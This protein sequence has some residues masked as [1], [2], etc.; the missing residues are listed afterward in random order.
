ME[1]I[2]KS[3][4][5]RKENFEQVCVWRGAPLGDHTG[6]DVER[7]F[8]EAGFR[9]QYLENVLT[10]PD[11]DELGRPIPETGGRDDMLI[12]IHKDDLAKFTVARFQFHISWIED[13]TSR[14]NRGDRLY[15][16]YVKA[17]NSWDADSSFTEEQI[18]S[19]SL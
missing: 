13:V 6:E 12:A 17:Y 18:Q 16:D 14:I 15:P 3:A 5:V 9:V 10:N 7:L 2:E 8:S 4:V 19:H 1:T 11:Y